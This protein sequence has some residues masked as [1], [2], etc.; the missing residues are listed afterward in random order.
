MLIVAQSFV[1]S[2]KIFEGYDDRFV[3]EWW[4]SS[5]LYQ[6]YVRSFKDSN[7]DGI[8]DL[9]GMFLQIFQILQVL[10]FS[11]ILIKPY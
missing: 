6:V 5:I 8:G 11:I 1:S 9:K 10:Q 7:G 2:E 3:P 4:Q